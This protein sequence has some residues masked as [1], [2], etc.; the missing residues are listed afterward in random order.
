MMTLLHPPRHTPFSPPSSPCP[1]SPTGGS[2]HTVVCRP[3]SM[4]NLTSCLNTPPP[5]PTPRLGGLLQCRNM[6]LQSND[7]SNML[8][9]HNQRAPAA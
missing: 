3:D 8:Q 1:P 6:L 2:V 5:P 9:Q 7:T 4:S